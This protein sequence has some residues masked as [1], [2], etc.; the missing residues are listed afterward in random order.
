MGIVW[1]A[2]GYFRERHTIWCH[3]RYTA[4]RVKRRILH[5]ADDHHAGFFDFYGALLIQHP[6]AKFVDVQYVHIYIRT[7]NP[8][9]D[10]TP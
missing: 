10:S 8:S 1:N 2:D 3:G 4:K 6:F 7:L 5:L 9:Q